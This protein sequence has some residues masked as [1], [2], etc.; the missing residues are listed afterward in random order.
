MASVVT[1]H[2]GLA[3]TRAELSS[4]KGQAVG[5]GTGCKG[6]SAVHLSWT[7]PGEGGG[8]RRLHAALSKVI[9]EE[10]ELLLYSTST[11]SPGIVCFRGR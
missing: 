7:T 3:P 10:I 6:E 9:P 1:S 5:R 4:L 8:G 11:V 2:R